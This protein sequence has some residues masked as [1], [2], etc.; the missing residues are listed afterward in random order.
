MCREIGQN[1]RQGGGKDTGQTVQDAV[2]QD[3]KMRLIL[4]AVGRFYLHKIMK[5]V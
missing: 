3:K 4:S 2:K 1:R 5:V